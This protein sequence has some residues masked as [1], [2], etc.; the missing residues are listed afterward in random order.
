MRGRDWKKRMEKIFYRLYSFP[1]GLLKIG[2]QGKRIFLIEKKDFSQ[3]ENAFIKNFDSDGKAKACHRSFTDQ[4]FIEI[5]EYLQGERSV[6][7]FSYQLEGSPFQK[8]VWKKILKIP[9]GETRTYKDIARAIGKPKASQAVGMALKK[10]P[11]L[12]AIPCHRVI[13]SDGALKGYAG[14]L[15]MKKALLDLERANKKK[16]I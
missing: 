13:G 11:I 2:C 1:F 8:R 7:N 3:T 6:F 10:N 16:F 12:I 9:Y 5:M 14:G 15:P 4:A